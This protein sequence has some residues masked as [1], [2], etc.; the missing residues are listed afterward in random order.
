MFTFLFHVQH[1]IDV[2]QYFAASSIVMSMSVCLSACISQT[3]RVQGLKFSVRINCGHGLVLSDDSVMY[4]GL[5]DY[6][7]FVHSRPGKDNTNRAYTHSDS[8]GGSTKGKV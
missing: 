5:V 6:V 1:R 7:M 3:P 4:F 2:F 8:P